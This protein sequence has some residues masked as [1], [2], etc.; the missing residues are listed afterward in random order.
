MRKSIIAL[1]SATI[2]F[3]CSILTPM[4]VTAATSACP[5]HTYSDTCIADRY[6]F[7]YS[8]QYFYENG[9]GTCYVSRHYQ[10]FYL[11]CPICGAIK[12]DDPIWENYMGI[13]HSVNH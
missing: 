2:I 12:F 10:G 1:C 6:E 13:V 4:T 5:P 7:I 11:R 9:V 3:A 8:H